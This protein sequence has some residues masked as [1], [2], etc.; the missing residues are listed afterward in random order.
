MWRHISVQVGRRGGLEVNGFS[1]RSL[2]SA[3]AAFVRP[4]RRR[5]LAQA[6]FQFIVLMAFLIG[7]HVWLGVSQDFL[8]TTGEGGDGP[9]QAGR[10]A[11][12]FDTACTSPPPSA[13]YFVSGSGPATHDDVAFYI[14]TFLF[15]TFVFCQARTEAGACVFLGGSCITISPDPSCADLQPDQR[16]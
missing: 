10:R 2:T 4:L 12:S 16:S 1:P 5:S 3:L 15:N 9:F 8:D 14:S 6:A 7:G 11:P 13:G